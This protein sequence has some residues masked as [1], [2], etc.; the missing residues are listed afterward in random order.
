M[1]YVSLVDGIA[2]LNALTSLDIHNTYIDTKQYST[3][4]EDAGDPLEALVTSAD[5]WRGAVDKLNSLK[6]ITLDYFQHMQAKLCDLPHPCPM[7]DSL[8]ITYGANPAHYRFQAYTGNAMSTRLEWVS[9]LCGLTQLD[10][11][12]SLAES[13][14]DF[15]SEDGEWLS[16]ASIK[17]CVGALTRL[18]SLVILDSQASVPGHI[19]S[20]LPGRG[21]N[22]T[23]LD[24][25]GPGPLV[26]GL[27]AVL[28]TCVNMRFLR[29]RNRLSSALRDS[30]IPVVSNMKC[31][32]KLCLDD[33]LTPELEKVR[34]ALR[35]LSS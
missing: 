22:L 27:L 16:L 8:H 10:F 26:H 34:N 13:A 3:D 32:R 15:E 6:T 25:H 11:G 18:S 30:L 35:F 33:G 24:V 12:T 5:V 28:Y 17:R 20:A 19:I 31:L 7:L 9:K 14:E 21:S 1:D 4:S 23:H 2:Y 29:L